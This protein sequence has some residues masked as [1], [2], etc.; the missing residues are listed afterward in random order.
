[1]TTPQTAS[2]ALTAQGTVLNYNS[3]TPTTPTWAQV[4]N[5]TDVSGF[6]GAANVIDVTNLSSTAKEKRLGLQDWGQVTLAIDTN[7]KEVSHS[8]LLA[9]KKAGSVMM[10]QLV[11]ADQSQIAF[12]AYVKDFPISAKVDQVVTGSVNLEVTGDITVTVGS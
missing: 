1:M 12:S 10:F 7:L 11:L 3:G 9:A 2:T 4:T 6:N 5:L 8:A